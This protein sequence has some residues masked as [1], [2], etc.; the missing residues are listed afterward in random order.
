MGAGAS[1]ANQEVA[2]SISLEDLAKA[3]RAAG[4][5]PN[6]VAA[7]KLLPYYRTR[8]EFLRDLRLIFSNCKTFNAEGSDLYADAVELERCL[9][10]RLL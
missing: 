7:K 4:L 8:A 10:G 3:A 1:L 2:G 6:V 5:D 9:E